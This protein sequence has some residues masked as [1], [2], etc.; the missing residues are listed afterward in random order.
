L[1]LFGRGG[2]ELSPDFEFVIKFKL[3]DKP[4]LKMVSQQKFRI[5]FRGKAV[6]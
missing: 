4:Q 1:C 2:S 3:D 5:R 6:H